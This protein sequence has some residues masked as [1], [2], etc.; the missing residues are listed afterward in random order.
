MQN[1]DQLID[2]IQYHGFSII[3]NFLPQNCHEQLL[4]LAQK[5]EADGQFKQARIGRQ[6]DTH[7]NDVI[8]RDKIL[9]LEEKS[10]HEAVDAYLDR[11]HQLAIQLNQTLFLGLAELETHFAIYEPGDFYRLH[12][13]QFSNSKNRQISCVYYL[14]QNWQTDFG[15]ELKLYNKTDQLIATVMPRGNRFICFTSDLP[16]EVCQTQQQR[17][18]I[19]GWLKKRVPIPGFSHSV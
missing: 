17:F 13:D 19:A 6:L 16:H 10:G 7:Q 1:I 18:S 12:V 2:D 9:W 8:R 5:L 3:D 4:Q 15:G 14:N 11:L